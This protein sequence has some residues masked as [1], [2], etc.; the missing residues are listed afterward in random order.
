MRKERVCV[1]LELEVKRIVESE[2]KSKMQLQ[3]ERVE[4]DSFSHVLEL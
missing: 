3:K 1:I 4:G 2:S